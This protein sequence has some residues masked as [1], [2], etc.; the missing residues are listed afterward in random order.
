MKEERDMKIKAIVICVVVLFA[1]AGFAQQKL[2]VSALAGY[3]MTAFEDQEK[4]VSSIV[5]G[6][7]LGYKVMPA[8]HIGAEFIYPFGYKDKDEEFGVEIEGTVNQMLIG[9]FAKY[10]FGSGGIMPFIKG[11]VGYYMGNA[12]WEGGG[13]SGDL[14]IDPKIGFN[15]GAGALHSSGFFA[16]F[17]YH[18]VTRTFEGVDEGMGMNTWAAMVGYQIIK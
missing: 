4:A 13:Q 10:F 1:A 5:V 6:A 9:A 12:K 16:E 18:I 7:A 2:V 3:S 14:D 15:F 11:G 17:V 8:L